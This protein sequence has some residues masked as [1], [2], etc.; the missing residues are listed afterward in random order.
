MKNELEQVLGAV[1]PPSG[2]LSIG[3]ASFSVTCSG[4]AFAVLAR[5][6][7]TFATV[8]RNTDH[9]FDDLDFWLSVLP[10]AF[11]AHCAPEMTPE[12][13]EAF[14]RLPIEERMRERPWSVLAWLHWFRS[15]ERQWY[16][17]RAECP[18]DCFVIVQVQPVDWPFAHG[19]LDWL[20][21]ACGAQSVEGDE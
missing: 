21:K 16:W 8:L 4:D 15:E 17:W 19:A 1:E 10:P 6:R 20:F 5:A 7:E 11:L 13:D 2:T 9:D 12:E 18:N 3:L 14:I